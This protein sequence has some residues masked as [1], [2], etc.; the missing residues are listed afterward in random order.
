M[1]E[2][3]FVIWNI[4]AFVYGLWQQITTTIPNNNNNN[5]QIIAT[6]TMIIM[7]RTQVA[8]AVMVVVAAS[9]P[10]P[11]SPAPVDHPQ[12]ANKCTPYFQCLERYFSL[13]LSKWT[14]KKLICEITHFKYLLPP[15]LHSHAQAHILKLYK[16]QSSTV[17]TT[18]PTTTK[19]MDSKCNLSCANPFDAFIESLYCPFKC[20]TCTV[21]YIFNIGGL[22]EQ[23]NECIGCFVDGVFNVRDFY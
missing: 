13:E 4:L 1:I 19:R 7:L 16:T 5:N 17:T 15:A 14:E 12:Y 20:W 11:L 3:C 10:I 22:N 9:T 2:D 21:E 23:V 6:M 18:T 8:A